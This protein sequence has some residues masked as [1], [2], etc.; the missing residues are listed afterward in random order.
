MGRAAAE[1][2]DVVVVTDDNPRS[3]DPASIRARVMGGARAVLDAAQPGSRLA[4]VQLIDG[5]ERRT[6]IGLA[7]RLASPS[8]AV[9]ILGKGHERTQQLADRTVEFDDVE[10]VRQQWADIARQTE[11]GE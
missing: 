10:V 1:G 5:G 2:A 11:G 9:A 6:A 7:L 4:T 8:D 3:E